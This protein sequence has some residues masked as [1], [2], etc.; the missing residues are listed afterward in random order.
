MRIRLGA[1]E[2]LRSIIVATIIALIDNLG[3]G[4]LFKDAKEMALLEVEDK[5]NKESIY[6]SIAQ[7]SFFSGSLL[8]WLLGSILLRT[9]MV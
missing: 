7:T 8:K 4:S 2:K 1:V 5:Y 6:A 9:E 3:C